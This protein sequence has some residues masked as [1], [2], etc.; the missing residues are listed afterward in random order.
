[1]KVHLITCF[2]VIVCV[3]SALAQQQETDPLRIERIAHDHWRITVTNAEPS[4]LHIPGD[5]PYGQVRIPGYGNELL[6]GL[7]SLPLRVVEFGLPPDGR[8]TVSI[9]ALRTESLPADLVA[10]GN[11]TAEV[12]G[13]D[14]AVTTR[15]VLR[16]GVHVGGLRIQP[17]R[18][19]ADGG[20]LHWMRSCILDVRITGGTAAG[21][22]GHPSSALD[23]LVN[24]DD[25]RS[26][27]TG[28]A[29]GSLQRRMLRAGSDLLR[30]VT[31]REG[32]H[33]ITHDD[34]RDAGFDPAQIDTDLFRLTLMGEELP[35][36]VRDGGDGSFDAGD[37]LLFYA[38]RKSGEDGEYYDEWS[39]EQ[40]FFLTWD[41]TPGARWSDFD[42][43]PASRPSAVSITEFPMHLHL[44]EDHDYHRGDQEY[45]DMMRT[46]RVEGETWI[47]GYLI[48]REGANARRDTIRANFD[49]TAPAAREGILRI[50]ARGASRDPS[51]LRATLNGTLIGERRIEPYQS[52]TAEWSIPA[53]LL[54]SSGNE[55]L[56]TNPGIIV[57]PPENPVCSIERF[58]V[59]WAQLSYATDIGLVRPPVS[60][61]AAHAYGSLVPPAEFRLD[62]P[63]TATPLF[64]YDIVRGNRLA[65]IERSG[66]MDRLAMDDAGRYYLYTEADIH[67]PVELRRI[68]IPDYVDDGRQVDYLVVTH[69]NFRA[70]AERLAEYRRQSDGYSTVVA[71]VAD[72]YNAYNEGHKSPAAIRAFVQEALERRPEPKPRFLLLVGDASWDAKQRKTTTVKVDFVPTYGNPVSD[73]YYVSFTGQSFDVTPS[74]SVGRIPAETAGQA[75]A[76]IDKII[77]YEQAPVRPWDDRFL[78]AV[79]GENRGEQDFFLKPKI[80]ALILNWARP[81]CIEDRLIVKRTLDFISYDDLDTLIHE[82][83]QGISWFIFAGHGGT[84]VIDIGIERPDIFDN[85]DKYIFFI[86]MSCN[87]AHFAEPFETGLNERFIISPRNGAIAALGTS[88]LGI[89][90]YDYIFNRGMFRALVDSGVRTYG[91]LVFRGKREL[92]ASY[93][94]GSQN[95]INSTNQLT[96]LGDPATRVPLARGPE[97]AV[98][99]GDVHTEPEIL[100]EQTAAVI[101][102]RMHNDGLCMGDS[103]DALLQVFHEGELR[104]SERRRLPPFAVDTLLLWQYDF[105]GIEGIAELHVTIDA[106]DEIIEKDESNNT[107]VLTVSV[108]PRGIT[109]IFPLDRAVIGRDGGELVF[110]LA[111]PSFVPDAIFDP[112]ARNRI[113]TGCH[114]FRCRTA[115]PGAIGCGVHPPPGGHA[116]SGWCM[117]LARPSADHC[118]PGELVRYAFLYPAGCVCQ[119][120]ALAAA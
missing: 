36:D 38:S 120:R 22:G 16:E 4:V 118:R 77:A 109:Q 75:E 47:W 24:S 1:M 29:A 23:A 73:N 56:L 112:R 32:I 103:V 113:R 28:H 37:A 48:K 59:D 51:M 41:G 15:T 95:A 104:H 119:R 102:T 55:L 45:G 65:G 44:E 116:C 42:V 5:P 99:Q 88:G 20:M 114:I 89:I 87:T 8:L 69:A 94:I 63:A 30:I 110:L 107:L 26:W 98:R 34:I 108:L 31:V 83:N 67:A 11:G 72:L 82:V 43:A 61:D 115:R 71:D 81:Y 60:I 14:Y 101:H 19:D 93:G 25:A 33:R 85:E 76:V 96:L 74:L 39:D 49:L 84:R 2:T 117:V 64:G 90:E 68:R 106:S 50:K 3:S 52:E 58:Y 10:F 100:I 35:L 105:A 21:G 57:C 40:V 12:A 79:G 6:A 46:E 17:A 54:L 97:L 70:Q 62:I 27:T 111:N 86:T 7:P 80:D 53:G 18:Y 9:Q 66:G 91:E 92:L 13:T 78:F